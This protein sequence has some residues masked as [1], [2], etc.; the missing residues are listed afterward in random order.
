M[1]RKSGAAWR[2]DVELQELKGSV[3]LVTGGSG[4]VGAN[5]VRRLL[6][7]GVKVHLL[8]RPK[9]NRWRLSGLEHRVVVHVGDITNP[10]VVSSVFRRIR[11]HF[12]IHCAMSNGHPRD[13][14]EERDTFCVSALGTLNLLHASLSVNI[15]KFVHTGSSTEYG[16]RSLP[17]TERLHMRPATFRG[18]AK[19]CAT[20]IC[21][22][23]ARRHT[24]PIVNLRL[25]SVYGPWEAPSRFIPRVLCVALW[26]GEVPLT[27][28]DA[29][30]DFVFVGDVV[31]AYLKALTTPLP[32]GS[33]FNIGTGKQWGNRQVV[34]LVAQLVGRPIAIKVGAHPQHPTDTHCWVANIDKAS[35]LLGWRPTNELPDGLRATMEWM[36]HHDRW[37]RK[38]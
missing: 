32:N 10:A 22:Y 26:G 36:R 38:T 19:A 24:L 18:L 12:V 31:D 1:E 30:H 20:I 16:M 33:V 9:T 29:Y 23:F 6:T 11:P 34:E 13:P 5:I 27:A 35:R 14:S 17:L 8:L 28:K 4:F 3:T 2:G 25:F 15:Q 37:Y 21:D 7:N